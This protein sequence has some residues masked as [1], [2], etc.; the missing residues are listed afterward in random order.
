M[1]DSPP[2]RRRPRLALESL[3]GRLLLSTTP[4]APIANRAAEIASARHVAA[5]RVTAGRWSW[6]ADTTW[7]VPTPN[8]SATIFD[9]ASG[10][11][12][13]VLDQTVY[14]ISGYRNGYFWGET[15]S[16]LGSGEPT[17]SALVGT[18]TPQG[19]LLLSFSS[20]ENVVQGYGQMTRK[21]GQWTMENQMFT[22]T[23]SGAQVG[24]WAYMVQTR[25]G[26]R[27]WNSLPSVGVSVPTFLS[28]YDRPGPSPIVR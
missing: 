27:S 11:L 24:H 1:L 13:P 22:L 25:P 8:L 2:R 17:S 23:S 5:P 4:R 15:V 20:S 19:R 10:A 18:V 12:V 3:E 7:Y 16:Q 26:M 28:N 9:P 14:H 21:H 6:L